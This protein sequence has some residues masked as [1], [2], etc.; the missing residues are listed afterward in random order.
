MGQGVWSCCQGLVRLRPYRAG[1]LRARRRV[2][3]VT[4]LR[5]FALGDAV[6]GYRRDAPMGLGGSQIPSEVMDL[7]PLWGWALRFWLGRPAEV[8]RLCRFMWQSIFR[9]HAQRTSKSLCLGRIVY[10]NIILALISKTPHCI[11]AIDI[12]ARCFEIP[13]YESG[14]D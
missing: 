3:D 13:V 8:T 6:G 10:R 11:Q 12:N 9:K 14:G 2:I 5:G 7:S 4:P 1:L